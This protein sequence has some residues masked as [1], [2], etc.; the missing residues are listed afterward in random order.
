MPPTA[1]TRR[2]P[3]TSRIEFFSSVWC[4]ANI[5]MT[6]SLRGLQHHV[7]RGAN[8]LAVPD[9]HPK[10][11]GHDECA[12][13]EQR[14]SRGPDYVEGVHRFHGFD[15]RIFEEPERCIGAPHQTLQDARYPH[16][17]HV[18]DDADGGD[19]EMP[20]DELEAVELFALPQPGN[21]AIER[22]KRHE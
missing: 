7:R 12:D 13:D 21:Q 22:S 8:R 6:S 16:R 10:I 17:R 14:P 11:V 15:E 18:E 20:I 2:I 4:L 9:G 19:P 5:D 1:I 3:I